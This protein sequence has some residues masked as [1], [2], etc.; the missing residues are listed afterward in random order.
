MVASAE[1]RSAERFSTKGFST[2]SNIPMHPLGCAI[3]CCRMRQRGCSS[4]VE[5]AAHNRL[6]VGSSPAAPTRSMFQTD[7]REVSKR[8]PVLEPRVSAIETSA[9]Q[10]R[11]GQ[12]LP[13]TARSHAQTRSG[14]HGEHRR[15]QRLTRPELTHPPSTPPAMRFFSASLEGMPPR[16][17]VHIINQRPEGRT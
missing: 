8:P 1:N 15:G 10:W 13:Q 6:R 9:R 16:R 11:T 5:P 12:S 7:G 2:K 17:G 14:E 3:W 4:T